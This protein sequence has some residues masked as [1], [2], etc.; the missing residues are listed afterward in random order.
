MTLGFFTSPNSATIL[1]V[2]DF[3]NW[4]DHIQGKGFDHVPILT[5]QATTPEKVAFFTRTQ[6]FPGWEYEDFNELLD[7]E[8]HSG[9]SRQHLHKLTRLTL[10]VLDRSPRPL[11]VSGQGDHSIDFQEI[12]I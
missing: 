2:M 7:D 5:R 9:A 11:G 10:R 1:V 3:K 12:T 6:T 8:I 4:I